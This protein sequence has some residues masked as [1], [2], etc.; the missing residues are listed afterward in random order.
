MFPHLRWLV[1]APLQGTITVR[2]KIEGLLPRITSLDE[3]FVT[4]RKNDVTEQMRRREL[5][6]YARI[7]PSVLGANFLL[8]RSN[9]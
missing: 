8:A 6:Q 1:N 5:I 9:P 7:T 2:N 3:H 4:L